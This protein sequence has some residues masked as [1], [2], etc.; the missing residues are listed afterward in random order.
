MGVAPT[1][2]GPLV[3]EPGHPYS[4]ARIDVEVSASGAPLNASCSF[5]AVALDYTAAPFVRHNV[6][7][8]PDEGMSTVKSDGP[9]KVHVAAGGVYT[10]SFKVREWPSTSAVALTSRAALLP[11]GLCTR[12]AGGCSRATR[13]A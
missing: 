11:R 4:W 5:M 7:R 1:V 10:F 2:E 3:H 8:T 9:T 6:S 12:G 13:V